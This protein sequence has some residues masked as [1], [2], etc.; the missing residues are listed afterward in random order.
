MKRLYR[1]NAG[2]LGGLALIG[3]LAVAMPVGTAAA[4]TSTATTS[5][6]ANASGESSTL[7]TD[8]K[9]LSDVYPAVVAAA[10]SELQSLA[11]ENDAYNC[12]QGF[13]DL[14]ST[15]SELG[16]VKTDLQALNLSTIRS[17]G[18]QLVAAL[19]QTEGD[20]SSAY[21]AAESCN[22]TLPDFVESSDTI[23]IS[24]IDLT[25]GEILILAVVVVVLAA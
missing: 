13:Q 3:G 12:F 25:I 22:K 19:E 14:K 5:G 7:T 18:V 10:E 16:I 15:A 20:L 23:E 11:S 24:G 17:D 4:A 21:G 9:N 2:V 6:T 8:L 1:W